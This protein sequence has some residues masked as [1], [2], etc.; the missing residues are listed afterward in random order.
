MSN[1]MEELRQVWRREDLQYLA[2]LKKTLLEFE[3]LYL[4]YFNG[5]LN[6]QI[7][8]LVIEYI[9][10][11]INRLKNQLFPVKSDTVYKIVSNA[12]V[13]DGKFQSD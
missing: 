12:E 11:E 3:A 1:I 9:V 10:S 13:V 4:K 5:P 6:R 8:R 7:N 2:Y